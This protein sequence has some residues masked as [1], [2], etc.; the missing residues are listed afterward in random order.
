MDTWLDHLTAALIAGVVILIL[1]AVWY[2][3]QVSALS[4]TNTYR[5]R[6][7]I[8][9]VRETIEHDMARLGA[10]VDK[11]EAA[12]LTYSWTGTT[13][14]F[15]FKGQMTSEPT[16]DRLRYRATQQACATSSGTCW[17]FVRQTFSGSTYRTSGFDMEVASVE[18]ALLPA[19]TPA[20]A[21]S[22]DIRVV[23]PAPELRPNTPANDPRRLPVSLDRHY[24]LVNQALR[25]AS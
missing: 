2:R 5:D 23:L 6:A 22:A 17:R 21:T 7:R 25:A 9:V 4:T 1:A 8:E 20:S 24:R 13:R 12:I 11:A 14:T 16:I 15:E 10:G 3:S 19:G 18:I